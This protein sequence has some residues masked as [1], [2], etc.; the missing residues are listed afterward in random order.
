[1]QPTGTFDFIVT[2]MNNEAGELVTLRPRN[3]GLFI[4]DAYP[5]TSSTGIRVTGYDFG[6]TAPG[7]Y[8]MSMVASDATGYYLNFQIPIVVVGPPAWRVENPV[9]TR[10]TSQSVAN[11]VNGNDISFTLT[12]PEQFERVGAASFGNFKIPPGAFLA[13][14][15]GVSPNF[16]F[17]FGFYDLPVGTYPVS[18]D[19]RIGFDTQTIRG[20]LIVARRFRWVIR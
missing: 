4:A 8:V 7:E 5:N 3:F 14:V 9:I 13:N 18:F 1:V 20:T 6:S 11:G 15:S 10:F 16:V 19:A 17:S 12:N 2:V